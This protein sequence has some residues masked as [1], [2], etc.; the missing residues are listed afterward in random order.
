M[1]ERFITSTLNKRDQQREIKLRP[2]KF[3]DFPGQQKIKERLELFVK[4]AK[5]RNEPLDHILLSGP[6]G[7]GKTTLAY[8]IAA[9]KGASIKSSSGPVIEKP[10]DLAGLLTSLKEGDVLFIDEI[11]RL[12]LSCFI[13]YWL[14]CHVLFV[15]QGH[16]IT[17]PCD[18]DTLDGY[19]FLLIQPN[20]ILFQID[21]S[22]LGVIA[23][24]LQALFQYLSDSLV[25]HFVHIQILINIFAD[26]VYRFLANCLYF[27]R[28]HCTVILQVQRILIQRILAGKS[29]LGIAAESI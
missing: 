8:I 2:D 26:C 5:E 29:L 24:R 23:I 15:V 25:H 9:E 28:H 1:S 7:L 27:H 17:Y 3:A 13:Q 21:K 11:H 16:S 12:F 14:A 20:G 19:A 6:P 18:S 10:G 22:L 4:A